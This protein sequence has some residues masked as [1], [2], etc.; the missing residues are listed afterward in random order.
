MPTAQKTIKLNVEH[1]QRHQRLITKYVDNNEQR[2]LEC[3]YAVQALV[4]GL[5]HPQGKLIYHLL[6]EQYG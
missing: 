4:H 1:L 3:L 6:L 5:E 2:G